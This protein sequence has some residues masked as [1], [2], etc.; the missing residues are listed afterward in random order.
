MTREEAHQPALTAFGGVDMNRR[1]L[2]LGGECSAR[3]ALC[4]SRLATV[5]TFAVGIGATTAAFSAVD[6]M[7]E[8]NKRGAAVLIALK[9]VEWQPMCF[10]GDQ[11][12]ND[13]FRLRGESKDTGFIVSDGSASR[14]G[15]LYLCLSDGA[16]LVQTTSARVA[17]LE[18]GSVRSGSLI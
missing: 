11:S 4:D 6:R 16:C 3:R 1:P 2:C 17:D 8:K 7:M 13:L 5:L 15:R 10:H 12:G 9:G 14:L 18:T